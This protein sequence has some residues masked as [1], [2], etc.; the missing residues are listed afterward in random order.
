MEKLLETLE[1]PFA[2]LHSAGNDAHFA[3]RALLM[4]ATRDAERQSQDLSAAPL[5]RTFTAIARA[6]RPATVGEIEV[7][8]REARQEENVARRQKRKAKRAAK[9]ERRKAQRENHAVSAADPLD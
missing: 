8:L 7:P 6:P 5:F 1:I 2:A 4:I 3:L 9:I